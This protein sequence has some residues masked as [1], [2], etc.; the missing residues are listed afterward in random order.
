MNNR[1]LAHPLNNRLPHLNSETGE[2]QTPPT[3]EAQEIKQVETQLALSAITYK[4]NHVP[5]ANR[6]LRKSTEAGGLRLRK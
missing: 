6:Y 4:A 5:Q 2:Q 3:S 1:S